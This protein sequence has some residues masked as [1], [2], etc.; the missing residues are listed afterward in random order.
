MAVTRNGLVGPI[1]VELV[2]EE[3]NTVIASAQILRHNMEDEIVGTLD[4][5]EIPG[6]VPLSGAQF[7]VATRN[8][9]VGLV[10]VSLVI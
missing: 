1:V 6:L 3:R 9:L 2:V 5:G 4:G 8:G 7:M 10:V